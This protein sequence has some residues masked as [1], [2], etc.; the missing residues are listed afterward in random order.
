[1]EIDVPSATKLSKFLFEITFLKNVRKL[2]R[3]I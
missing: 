1:M 3:Q 2:L